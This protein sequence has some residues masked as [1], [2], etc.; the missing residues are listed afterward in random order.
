MSDYSVNM[1]L[2]RE[3]INTPYNSLNIGLSHSRG[4]VSY[5]DNSQQKAG[6]YLHFRAQKINKCDNYSTTSFA[7][8]DKPELCFKVNIYPK[9]R[10]NKKV[11][12]EL[13]NIAY[14]NRQKLLEAFETL[15]PINVFSLL[16]NLYSNYIN[17]GDC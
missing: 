14:N 10:K 4:G 15:T 13:W 16:Q 2:T 12:L 9:Y 11:M 17:K 3:I 5:F 6:Y 8:F 7:L 1:D